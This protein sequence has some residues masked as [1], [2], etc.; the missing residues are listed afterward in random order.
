VLRLPFIFHSALASLL[1]S[2]YAAVVGM[3]SLSCGYVVGSI[4]TPIRTIV[5][6]PAAKEA[7]PISR[8]E[9]W[10]K[11][12]TVV[13]E[14]LDPAASH[15]DLS[16]V[17]GFPAAALQRPVRHAAEMAAAMDQSE[18]F[19]SQ[20]LQPQVASG[21]AEAEKSQAYS[22]ARIVARAHK[23]VA[24]NVTSDVAVL[25]KSARPA[26]LKSK[27]Q[28]DDALKLTAFDLRNSQDDVPK[29]KPAVQSA[30]AVLFNG[31]RFA[32]SPAEIVLR[33]LRG[34]G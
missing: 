23:R 4:S 26:S 24:T 15:P 11:S 28:V 34:M 2:A 22:P 30:A 29:S 3:L 12:Q 33:S 27:K 32:D 17:A 21:P 5:A 1:V 16:P 19:E 6:S 10:L 14:K 13:Y 25:R 8:V 18:S 9:Q 7:R 20:V 31:L